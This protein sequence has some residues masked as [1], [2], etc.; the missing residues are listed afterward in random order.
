MFRLWYAHFCSEIDELTL[1]IYCNMKTYMVYPEMPTKKT[2]DEEDIHSKDGEEKTTDT[3]D[4]S[5]ANTPGEN[6]PPA[7]DKVFDNEESDS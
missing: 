7:N 1:L 2:E 3:E 5:Q 6:F 4:V